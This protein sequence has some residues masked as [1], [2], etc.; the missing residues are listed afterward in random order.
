M[1]CKTTTLA[2][3][4][5]LCMLSQFATSHVTYPVRLV[6]IFLLFGLFPQP[7]RVYH[8]QLRHLLQHADLGAVFR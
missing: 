7:F 3:E 2:P 8:D 6:R 1:R 5:R 4:R